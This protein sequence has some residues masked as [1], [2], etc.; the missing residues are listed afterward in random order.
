MEQL[1]YNLLFRW[2]V[3]LSVDDPVW[4]PTV[5]SKNRDR[6]LEGEIAAAFMSAVLNLPQVQGPV[7]GRTF[8]GRRHSYKG[9]GEHEELPPQGW[10]GRT[11]RAG[12]QRRAQ[13]PGREAIKRDARL[14]HRSGCTAGQE[15]RRAGGE[16]G[17]HWASADGKQER[18]DRECAP[19]AC[20]RHGGAGGGAG[21]AGRVARFGEEDGRSATRTTT[22]RRSL[23]LHA[24]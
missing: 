19:D 18:A 12:P 10:A 20:D 3:G 4:V 17:L 1:N 7:V 5:F 13:L 15:V 9:L 23:P 24:V 22:L 6:L 16:A 21:D 8:L 2:F 14:D 11:A